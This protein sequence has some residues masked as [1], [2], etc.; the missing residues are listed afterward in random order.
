MTSEVIPYKA[1]N[2][3]TLHGFFGRQGGISRGDYSSL[4]CGWGSGDDLSNVTTNRALVVQALG[5]VPSDLLSAAQVHSARVQVVDKVW[6]REKSPEVDAMVTTQP[7]V[8]LGVLSA[9]CAP[10]L[11]HDPVHGV[12][13]AAHAGWKG[14]FGGVLENT[15]AAME[16][17]G[18]TRQTI[19]AAIGPCIH[20]PSYEVDQGFQ[21]RFVAQDADFAAYFQE[22]TR[23]GHPLFDLPR[24][25]LDRLTRLGLGSVTASPHDTYQEEEAYFSFRRTT[26]RGEADYGRQIS[27][28]V[29]EEK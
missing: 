12:I 1:S 13:G 26:H 4:N 10:I 28:I 21:D 7:R 15:V 29:L 19:H 17:L 20:Q 8:A 27:V 22:G 16:G 25:V 18:A 24:F 5:N 11:F 3:E 9:D 6:T 23:A 2:L 14:A